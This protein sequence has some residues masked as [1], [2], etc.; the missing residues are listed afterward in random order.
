MDRH[1]ITTFRVVFDSA[2][3]I[4][5]SMRSRG[6]ESLDLSVRVGSHEG[7]RFTGRNRMHFL[8]EPPD[9]RR[10]LRSNSF[11]PRR[12]GVDSSLGLSPTVTAIAVSESVKETGR[13]TTR[14]PLSAPIG[15]L[16]RSGE[17]ASYS[18]C[19]VPVGV[20]EF[21]RSRFDAE[22][23]SGRASGPRPPCQSRERRVSRNRRT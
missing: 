18:P 20:S 10:T 14:R 17:S 8:Q 15:Y 3:R 7:R 16:R 5:G 1:G 13:S 11:Y 2:K 21:L 4:V 23:G 6:A 22:P 12:S 19:P 9:C